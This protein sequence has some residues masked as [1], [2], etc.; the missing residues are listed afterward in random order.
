MD[1][2]KT[3]SQ[4]DL[5]SGQSTLAHSY[6]AQSRYLHRCSWHWCSQSGG[7]HPAPTAS[8][9]S[10]HLQRERKAEVVDEKLRKEGSVVVCQLSPI[11][12]SAS[13]SQ[14]YVVYRRGN[15]GTERWWIWKRTHFLLSILI[16]ISPLPEQVYSWLLS[17]SDFI[18]NIRIEIP[19]SWNNMRDW[20]SV[21]RP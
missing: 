21:P 9:G 1:R 19:A 2:L 20:L 17:L 6:L 11:R 15:R 3:A 16:M 10:G 4:L 7:L 8:P 14:L 12:D 13:F 18:I 5:E